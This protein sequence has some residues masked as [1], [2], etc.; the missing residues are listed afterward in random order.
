[1]IIKVKPQ[2]KKATV[3]RGN[4]KE[5]LEIGKTPNDNMEKSSDKAKVNNN[6]VSKTDLVSQSD[7]SED[8]EFLFLCSSFLH[9]S[10][11]GSR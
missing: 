11:R 2:A 4:V 5:H 8:D 3:D 10:S 6:D 9:T 7:E 1:M